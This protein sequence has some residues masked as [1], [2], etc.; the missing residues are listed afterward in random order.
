MRV[1]EGKN[2]K[3]EG[4][5]QYVIHVPYL[6]NIYNLKDD[7]SSIQFHSNTWRNC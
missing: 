7:F 2:M 3:S 5:V 4:Y 6:L 1:M